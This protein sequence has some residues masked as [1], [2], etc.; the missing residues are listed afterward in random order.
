MFYKVVATMIALLCMHDGD[1]AH[2]IDSDH[3]H[4][5]APSTCLVK[6]SW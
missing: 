5:L 1:Y 6:L 3:F 4:M 2:K